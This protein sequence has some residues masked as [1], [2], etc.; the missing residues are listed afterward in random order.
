MEKGILR[1]LKLPKTKYM[2]ITLNDDLKKLKHYF[3]LQTYIPPMKYLFDISFNKD[4]TFENNYIITGLNISNDDNIKGNCS[5]NVLHDGIEKNIDVYLK[6]THLIDPIRSLQ[7]KYEDASIKEKI[8][9]HWNQA[10]VE[11]VASYVLGKLRSENISL[12][13]NLFYGAFTSIAKTYNYNVSDE[14]DSY[15]M[16]RWFWDGVENN[17]LK[18]NIEGEDNEYIKELY[19]NIMTKPEYCLDTKDNG[20]EELN[21]YENIDSYEVKSLDSASIHTQTTLSTVISSD[22]SES[23]DEIDDDDYKVFIQL[24]NFPVMMIFTEKN[25]STMDDLLEDFETVGAKP[26][27][28][29][30]DEKWSAWLFQVIAGLCVAQ[31]LFGFTHNDLHTNNIVW[32]NTSEKYFYYK[33]NN[34]I[35]FRVPTY[36]K[37]FKIIDFGRSIFSINENIFVS[38]DFCEGNDAATQYNFPP[39]ILESDEERVYPNPSFDLTRL[40]ISLLEPLFPTKPEEKSDGIILSNEK[41][42]IVK[43]TKSELFNILWLW[44]I[45]K[46]G[47]NILYDE[48]DDE[49]FPDFD[50]Y[51]HISASCLNGVPKEQIYKKP[52]NRFI[53]DTKIPKNVKIYSLFV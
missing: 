35:I 42:R 28:K 41:G 50:L 4:I 21:E 25:I 2:N 39:L 26:K 45:D 27:T 31:T 18:I 43:E 33:T 47:N 52:F 36:G 40:S 49:R 22:E 38:D 1:G 9:N 16:Y 3:N 11:T 44:L 7:K 37:V 17:S 12:H 29:L 5:I 51:T 13:F 19:N 30:W 32:S 53:I 23:D 34:N 15:K 6:V 24:P 20:V 46:E 48:E 8:E 10:Y 14:I